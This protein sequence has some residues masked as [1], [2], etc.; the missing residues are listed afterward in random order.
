MLEKQDETID[1]IRGLRYDLK[2]YMEKRFDRIE[3]EIIAIK[4]K[5][6]IV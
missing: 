1:E 3:Q 2:A 5:I 4:E 6:G